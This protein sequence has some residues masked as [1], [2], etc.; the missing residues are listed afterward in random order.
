VIDASKGLDLVVGQKTE[1]TRIK[2]S[3]GNHYITLNVQTRR[4]LYKPN[5]STMV[6]TGGYRAWTIQL[7]AEGKHTF[8][9]NGM[10]GLASLG[11]SEDEQ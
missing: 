3:K 5:G 4:D 2:D 7:T 1:V 6:T 8:W 11:V 9:A 10:R